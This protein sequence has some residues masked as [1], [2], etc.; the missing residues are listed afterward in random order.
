MSR[1]SARSTFP[2][3]PIRVKFWPRLVSCGKCR[4]GTQFGTGGIA[5]IDTVVA[6]SGTLHVT[7]PCWTA[8][9]VAAPVMEMVTEPLAGIVPVEGLTKNGRGTAA[10]LKGT[11]CPRTLVSRTTRVVEAGWVKKVDEGDASMPLGDGGVT[12]TGIIR[13]VLLLLKVKTAPGRSPVFATSTRKRVPADAVPVAG[14]T[15]TDGLSDRTLNSAGRGDR[16]IKYNGWFWG[17]GV[18]LKLMIS[19]TSITFQ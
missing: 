17:P 16:L 5:T 3:P 18:A 19:G 12:C 1:T 7:L 13:V 15:V 8:W 10:Q 4:L 9:P 11:L 2:N 6:P 14:E